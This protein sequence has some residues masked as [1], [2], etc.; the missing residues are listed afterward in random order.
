MLR[1]NGTLTYVS[2]GSLIKNAPNPPRV[3]SWVKVT[4]EWEQEPEDE[5]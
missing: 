2:V 3:G 1:K 4:V 5:R